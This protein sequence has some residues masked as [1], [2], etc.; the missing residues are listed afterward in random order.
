MQPWTRPDGD[1]DLIVSAGY[2]HDVQ[3]LDA[4]AKTVQL[5]HLRYQDPVALKRAFAT[6][7][8]TLP[9]LPRLNLPMIAFENQGNDGL[10]NRLNPGAWG[11]RRFTRFCHCRYG[12]DGDQICGQ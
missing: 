7:L 6:E 1:S 3:D 11:L 12:C 10:W 5:Q 2:P 9:I 4:I 8:G